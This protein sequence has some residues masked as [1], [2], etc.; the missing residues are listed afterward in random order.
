MDQ[1]GT[2][3][4][5]QKKIKTNAEEISILYA[6]GIPWCDLVEQEVD[7]PKGKEEKDR[8]N[9]NHVCLH[10][11]TEVGLPIAWKALS[12][13]TLIADGNEDQ[14]DG[15]SNQSIK[16]I[17]NRSTNQPA[18]QPIDRTTKNRSANRHTNG[19]ESS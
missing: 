5:R 10:D 6:A 19:H 18:D 17:T 9:R 1:Y 7:I 11:D 12:A 4:R 8:L 15:K 14:L 13:L 3:R 16:I 2:I